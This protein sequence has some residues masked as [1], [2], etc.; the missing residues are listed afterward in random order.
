VSAN[1]ILQNFLSEKNFPEWKWV[2]TGMQQ[3]CNNGICKIMQW[4]KNVQYKK[5]P[6]Y[7]GLHVGTFKCLV[8]STETSIEY[9]PNK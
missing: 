2:F 6:T 3:G 1:H 4:N 8:S 5:K 9:Q 7:G